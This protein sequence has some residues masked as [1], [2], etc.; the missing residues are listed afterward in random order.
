MAREM[1]KL[2]TRE[3][4]IKCGIFHFF[5]GLKRIEERLGRGDCL[6]RTAAAILEGQRIRP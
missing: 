1:R 4:L 6:E 3:K 2:R 5:L